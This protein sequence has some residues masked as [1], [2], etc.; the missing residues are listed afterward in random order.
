MGG[1]WT[2]RESN[3]LPVNWKLVRS[4]SDLAKKFVRTILMCDH[5]L[6]CEFRRTKLSVAEIFSV[7]INI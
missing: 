3:L 6:N 2:E 1:V 5:T 7:E 4:I